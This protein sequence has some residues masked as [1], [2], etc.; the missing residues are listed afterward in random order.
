MRACWKALEILFN[1]AVGAPFSAAGGRIIE[2][3]VARLIEARHDDRYKTLMT[4]KQWRD[5]LRS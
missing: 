3:T 5:S 4:Y 1:S 2:Q